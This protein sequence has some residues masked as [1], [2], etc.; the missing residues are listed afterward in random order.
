MDVIFKRLQNAPQS[1]DT[2]KCPALIQLLPYIF[3]HFKVN[4][5]KM[6]TVNT[7]ASSIKS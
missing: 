7:A 3:L 5:L 1:Q 2:L 4:A 6:H